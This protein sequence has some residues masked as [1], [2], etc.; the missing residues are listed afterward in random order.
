MKVTVHKEITV[1]LHLTQDEAEWLHAAMQN[2][3]IKEES[4]FDAQMR[5]QLFDATN[6]EEHK[7]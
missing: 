7:K 3:F 4:P 6:I 2:Q 1:T 5:R